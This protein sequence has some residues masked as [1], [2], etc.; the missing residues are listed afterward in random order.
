MTDQNN[1]GGDYERPRRPN[2]ETVA[3]LKS[4]PLDSRAAKEEISAFLSSDDNDAEFPSF[5][6]AA[7]SAI[8]EVRH[9]VASL[10]GDEDASQILECMANIAI[11][12][13]ETAARVLLNG[14]SGYHVH[15][16]THRYGSHVVQTILQLA[17]VAE[18][19]ATED[20]GLH[21][22]GPQVEVENVPS[23]SDLITAMVEELTPMASQLAM[24]VCG[25]HVLRTLVCVVG[26]VQLRSSASSDGLQRRGREKSKKKKKKKPAAETGVGNKH[27]GTMEINYFPPL[28]VTMPVN[29]L[30]TLMDSLW[31]SQK[32][33]E[34]QQMACHPSA[35]PLLM[36]SLRV[37]TFCHCSNKDQF[38]QQQHKDG[39]IDRD[40]FRLGI[41]PEQPQFELESPAHAF[42][43]RLL[44]LDEDGVGE[45]IYGMSGEPRGSHV[46]ETL[47][48]ISPDEVYSVILDKGD[49]VAS[50]QEYAEHNVSNF[51]VQ[52]LCATVRTKE[53]AET[54]LKA[55]EKLISSG[56]VVDATQ[57]R[58]GI[59]WRATELAAK[60]R[61][62]QEPL[63]KALRLGTGLVTKKGDN[64]AVEEDQE[65]EGKKKK[66]RQKANSLPLQDC[67][68]P[69]LNAK[70]PQRDGDRI[71]VGVEGTRA[72]YHLLRFA[73]RLCGDIMD[74]ITKNLT[75]EELELL[76]KDGLGSRCIWDGILD[77]PE[78][79]PFAKAARNLLAK[80]SGRWV[81]LA[82][83]RV[84]HHS[85][86]KL[87]TVLNLEDKAT[88]TAELAQ[89]SN[90]LG[91]SAM[92]RSVM[93]ACAVNAF[94]DGEDAWN[95][96]VRKL[97]KDD[98]WV[99][100]LL[101]PEPSGEGKKKRKRKR[102]Q[103]DDDEGRNAK[104]SAVD[105]IVDT[106]TRAVKAS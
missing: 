52:A 34:L 40:N 64:Q 76:A 21:Q 43:K 32:H 36:I 54:L 74:G 30:Q 85:V 16:A 48:R 80:L 79:K 6:A 101:E 24:H 19:T 104:A 53:Q 95:N 62:Q 38:R 93:E 13:S 7:L 73:P 98:S 66:Q 15:L 103:A 60:F 37:L 89:G 44:L 81:A 90:R 46:L 47:M 82:S 78:E 75:V 23:L 68:A 51:V 10:A 83:D 97:Q 41:V 28:R 29:L 102:K 106:I 27:A 105:A 92:G 88:L 70:M 25:S 86:M 18:E 45:V 26:G 61:V 77:G 35:G 3:Y 5:L 84:G 67:I 94:L 87:F 55:M 39:R 4:L 12:Y 9:E 50:L 42:C 58:V 8:D 99:N 33:G 14:L 91:G 11:P 17:V 20:L 31:G 1:G 56:L 63:L 2:P 69:L 96:A 22:D 100:E 71:T 59:F 57:K 49:F 65:E 72:V